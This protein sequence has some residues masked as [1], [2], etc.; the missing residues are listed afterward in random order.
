MRHFYFFIF[1]MGFMTNSY[2]QFESGKKFK[3]IPPSNVSPK[4]EKKTTPP[5]TTD[6]PVII[7]PNVYKSPNI[8]QSPPNP[9]EDYKVKTKSEISMIPKND[10]I[11]PGDEIKDR[12][13]KSINKDLVDN[14]LKENDSYV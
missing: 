7:P 13:S 10:F 9:V 3:A 12:L 8:I 11:N 2:A 1:L 5:P 4:P 14:G 6:F